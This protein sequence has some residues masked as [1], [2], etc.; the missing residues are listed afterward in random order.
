MIKIYDSWDTSYKSVFGAIKQEEFCNF[1]IRLDDEYTP[2]YDPVMIIYRTGFKERFIKMHKGETADGCTTYT[3]SFATSYTGVYFYYFCLTVQSKRLYIKKIDPHTGDICDGDPFQLTVFR[4]DFKTPSYLKGGIMYQIFPDR[5]CK[6]EQVHENIPDDRLIRDDWGGTPEYRPHPETKLWNYDFFGG[7]LEGIRSK[8]SYLHDLGVTCIYLTPIFESH[9]NHRYSV[10]NYEKVD[11]MLGTNKDFKTLCTDAHKYGIR[12]I[13]DGVF[14][15]TGANSIYFN[16]YNFYDS[17][18]AY[19]SPDSKYYEWYIFSDYPDVYE[20]WWGIDSLPNVNEN[21]D[22]YTNY[23]CADDGILHKWCDLGASGF[24]LDVA[25]ELPDEFL[26]KVCKSLKESDRDNII[27]GE[28]WDDASNKECCGVHRR[29]LLGGQL[30]SV[31][32]YPLRDAVIDF[33]KGGSSFEFRNKVMTLL[34]NYPKP[35]VDVLMNFVSTHDVERAITVFGDEDAQDKSREWQADHKMTP[36]QYSKGKNLFKL[37]M[38]LIY[39]LP[40]VPCIYYGD[41]AG[42]EGY[43]DPF[44][45]RCYP[46]GHEDNELIEYIKKLSAL[47]KSSSVFKDG[48]LKFLV[49]DENILG[50]ARIKKNREKAVA[51]FFNR[52]DK[53]QL[54][55][56]TSDMQKYS[57]YS[58][59]AGSH[60]TISDK[61]YIKIDPYSFAFIKIEG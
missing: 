38:A 9:E 34:E 21:C 44:N 54:V 1:T 37:A 52:S 22:S 17:T 4:N 42:V 28:V 29:Y 55:E 59:I 11:P 24:R 2:D 45:R 27:I 10:A 53:V 47:R 51:V 13:L 31:M 49:Y 58:I 16:K 20:A 25:D 46:W 12:I 32:N 8:L 23:I 6:S 14:S 26:Y 39:F 43:K 57:K 61:E 41:E 30:D 40:G 36:E 3:A 18:G 5:F 56:K 35:S 48:I 33:I 19:N 15:H 60:Q 7:D 50:F